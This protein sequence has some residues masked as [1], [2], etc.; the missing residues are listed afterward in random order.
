MRQ[1]PNPITDGWKSLRRPVVLP[2]T[3]RT[4]GAGFFAGCAD[5]GK[6]FHRRRSRSRPPRPPSGI[7]RAP[8]PSRPP[9]SRSR[10]K[11]KPS[12]KR[13]RPN[14]R[15]KPPEGILPSVMATIGAVPFLGC[16][17]PETLC[18]HHAA[19]LDSIGENGFRNCYGLLSLKRIVPGASMDCHGLETIEQQ[20]RRL[21]QR[22][23]L[24]RLLQ[25]P[26]AW[27]KREENERRGL[28][29]I[30][31]N[32]L[33]NCFELSR[34]VVLIPISGLSDI[35]ASAFW[36]CHK[37]MRPSTD[38]SVDNGFSSSRKGIREEI[39]D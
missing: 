37:S 20:R 29:S 13:R 35:E 11:P 23:R 14:G 1:A 4:I 34:M 38:Y 33:A 15:L 8:K 22:L 19:G 39:E 26:R 24:L 7:P 3:L 16:D 25:P 18:L 9:R 31:T 27:E 12:R 32:A 2:A 21:L 36:C 17:R 10:T 6:R 28:E 5:L 30:G